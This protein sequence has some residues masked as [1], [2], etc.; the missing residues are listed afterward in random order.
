[1]TSSLHHILCSVAIVDPLIDTQSFKLRHS[2]IYTC[3]Y[4]YDVE[5]VGDEFHHAIGVRETCPTFKSVL[6]NLHT[7]YLIGRDH[8]RV[9][10]VVEVY[11]CA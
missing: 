7:A 5:E 8:T 2:I 1:M 9:R 10:D 6:E 11:V 3:V 4:V